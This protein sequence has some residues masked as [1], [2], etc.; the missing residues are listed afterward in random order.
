MHRPL[1]DTRIPCR[2]NH[3]RLTIC[4][5]IEGRRIVGIA[6]PYE[7]HLGYTLVVQV[8]APRRAGQVQR[9]REMLLA[10][11]FRGELLTAMTFLPRP[12]GDLDE[13]HGVLLAD[14]IT[15]GDV[16]EVAVVSEARGISPCGASGVVT[17]PLSINALG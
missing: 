9:P 14:H 13:L 7:V 3:I 17:M 5:Y 2:V 15:L 12:G 10:R 1:R 6:D 8:A 4:E 16:A 11:Q